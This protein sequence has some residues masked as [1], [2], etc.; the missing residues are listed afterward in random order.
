MN[1]ER[2][3]DVPCGTRIEVQHRV[4]G[5]HRDTKEI[6]TFQFSMPYGANPEYWD[7]WGGKEGYSYYDRLPMEHSFRVV[8]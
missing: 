3:C 7:W 1:Y 4:R 6:K 8:G 2:I 5:I